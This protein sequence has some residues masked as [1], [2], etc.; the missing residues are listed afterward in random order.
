VGQTESV[1]PFAT[2]QEE[3][4]SGSDRL[5]AQYAPVAAHLEDRSA[6]F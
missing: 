3:A 2:T 4:V 1:C 6:I 5:L